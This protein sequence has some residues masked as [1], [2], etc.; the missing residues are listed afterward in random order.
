MAVSDVN[1]HLLNSH[2]HG[3][4]VVKEEIAIQTDPFECERCVKREQQL[5]EERSLNELF[6]NAKA[7]KTPTKKEKS[8]VSDDDA[9][10][11]LQKEVRGI[12]HP[13]KV[14]KFQTYTEKPGVAVA[15]AG[16]PSPSL[17]A[18]ARESRLPTMPSI[19]QKIDPSNPAA[20]IAAA[21]PVFPGSIPP[22][23]AAANAIPLFFNQ[24]NP[25]FANNPIFQQAAAAASGGR[26]ILETTQNNCYS[27]QKCL[28]LRCPSDHQFILKATASARFRLP[29]KCR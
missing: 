25:N 6:K 13:A 29:P 3:R 17:E 9:A 4:A 5:K 20:S 12:K 21:F 24:F 26:L 27:F 28:N 10:P 15:V 23:A 1:N 22:G 19:S 16:T 18:V 14:P 7:E 8:P 2:V 11:T